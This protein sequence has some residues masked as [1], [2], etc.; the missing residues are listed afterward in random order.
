MDRT[1][2]RRIAT[3]VLSIL[4]VASAAVPAVQAQTK[5]L[6]PVSLR[7]DIFF[8]GSHI[9]LIVGLDVTAA[10]GQ[11]SATTIQTV[12]NG[13]DNFG[14]ADAGTL[15]RLAAQGVH[16]KDVF[17]IL[18]R[19]PMVILALPD[20][21]IKKPLDLA[22]K[23]GGFTAGSAPEQLFPAFAKRN[24]FDPASVKQIVVDIPTRD[25]IFI[26]KKTDFTF[27][28]SVSQL[29]LL[30]EKC[31]CQLVAFRYGD[32]GLPSVSNGIIVSDK[33]AA[34]HPEIVKEFVLATAEALA[35]ALKDPKHGVD[36]FYTF[37]KDSPISRDV[38]ARQFAEAI[39]LYRT[40]ATEKKPYGVM[41]NGDWVRS[42]DL[43]VQNAGVPAGAVKP[44]DV[45]TNQY[46]LK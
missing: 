15:I 7:T 13:S 37:A 31:K 1:T 32:H 12:A 21:G 35:A 28:Y 36:D 8:N 41:D 10:P 44:E 34:D 22:G 26:A 16:A 25:S 42:I 11:G 17:G 14:Y 46:L 2:A 33:F 5:P 23:T 38:V 27:G 20:S 19:N 24:G 4:V 40:P 43:L 30:E 39:K 45:Y 18:Q 6:T 9:P 29:P 3:A